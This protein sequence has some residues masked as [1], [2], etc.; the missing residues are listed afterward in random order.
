MY[1]IYV[2]AA[3]ATRPLPFNAGGAANIRYKTTALSAVPTKSH[4]R[5][6]PQR[7][8]VFATITP[9]TGSLN[10]SN[11]LAAIRIIPMAIALTPRIS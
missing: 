10:A 2:T 4:G 3:Y 8:L 1:K 6:F 11:T 9:I 7:V 5:N